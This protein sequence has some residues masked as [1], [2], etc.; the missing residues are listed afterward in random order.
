MKSPIMETKNYCKRNAS[1]FMESGLLLD[2]AAA[3]KKKGIETYIENF[4]K[5]YLQH[6]TEVRRIDPI[7]LFIH[8][9]FPFL[10]GIL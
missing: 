7:V 9:I 4:Q 2:A 6:P 1:E 5:K 10:K 3:A 8:T